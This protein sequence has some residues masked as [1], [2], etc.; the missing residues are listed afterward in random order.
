MKTKIL[1]I[2]SALVLFIS[3]NAHALVPNTMLIDGVM[4][5]QNYDL[6]GKGWEWDAIEQILYLDNYDGTRIESPSV[7]LH[8]ELKSDSIIRSTDDEYALKSNSLNIGAGD[9]ELK[10]TIDAKNGLYAENEIKTNNVNF[11]F[12]NSNATNLFKTNIIGS[13]IFIKNSIMYCESQ[14]KAILTSS[15]MV[16]LENVAIEGFTGDTIF[17]S[18]TDN[19]CNLNITD[20]NI[21][22][23]AQSYI[24][25]KQ[26][27]KLR[28]S[29]LV[30]YGN[31]KYGI[32]TKINFITPHD[33]FYSPDGFNYRPY[34]YESN[35]IHFLT[36]VPQGSPVKTYNEVIHETPNTG[37]DL[38]I[39]L[40]IMTI[41]LLTITLITYYLFKR[42]HG[43]N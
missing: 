38:V 8:I 36:I 27:V 41:S 16:D 40:T 31:I 3:I 24:F 15:S 34:N 39:M 9:K 25:N 33:S 1:F 19:M 17:E 18:N 35:D 37:D 2:L 4:Y 20:S 7:N 21:K 29:S 43:E 23:Y 32:E 26:S 28:N 42:K 5:Y 6:K 10:L 12:I 30:L 22:A 14:R 11:N 13:T